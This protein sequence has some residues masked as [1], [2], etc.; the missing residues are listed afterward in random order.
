MSKFVAEPSPAPETAAFSIRPVRDG[1]EADIYRLLRGDESD[2]PKD[3]P[4]HPKFEVQRLIEASH[5]TD[6]KGIGW[7]AVAADGKTVGII[8]TKNF[9]GGIF[10]EPDYRRMGIAEA[11]VSARED[12]QRDHGQAEATAH[13]RADNKGSIRLHEKLGYHFDKASSGDPS[14]KP[15]S[16]ILV[17]T[18]PLAPQKKHGL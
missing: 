3:N 11:L 13:I 10:V 2:V 7:L 17:M 18:K 1:D 16:T 4:R 14:K 6:P 9:S 15:G 8:T 5:E 12:F